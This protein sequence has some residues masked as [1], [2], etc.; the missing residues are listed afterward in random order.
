MCRVRGRDVAAIG[1]TQGGPP[2]W[3]TYFAVENADDAVARIDKAGGTVVAPPMDVFTFGRMAVAQDPTGGFFSV[4]Q[5]G[6]HIGA[7]IVNEPN[8][9]CWNELNARD[10]EKAL[11]FYTKVFGFGV[12]SN[13][14]AGFAYHEVQVGGKT[15]GGAME[16]PPGVPAEVP[17]YWMPYFAVDDCDAAMAKVGKL[18][19]GTMTEPMDIPAG[20]FGVVRDPY[21]AVFGVIKM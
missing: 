20:R 10:V 15:V 21:G 16:M 18:G 14:S 8:A 19:G 6:E 1:P 17:T 4:W 7:S 12:Q 2:A 13:D 5:A 3:N 11:D 9:L